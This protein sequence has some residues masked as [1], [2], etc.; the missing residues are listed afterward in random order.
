MKENIKK[1]IYNFFCILPIQKKKIVL[2]NFYNKAYGDNPKYIAEKLKDSKNNY[3]LVWITS[4]KN[5]STLPKKIR[6]AS[7]WIIVLYEYA[8]AKI[9]ISNV[10]L[11]LYLKKRKKQFY[12]QTW[13]GGLGLKKCENDIKETLSEKYIQMMEHDNKMIDLALSNSTF[14]TDLY[15]S[16]MK[17]NGKI[18]E[19]G[20]PRNDNLIKKSEDKDQIKKIFNLKEEKILLYAP[21][22]RDNYRNNVYN[23]DFNKVLKTLEKNGDEWK[24]L[25][26][27]H[28]NITNANELVKF[29][30]KIINCTNYGDINEL[31]KISDALITDYSSCMFDFM[32]LEKPIY[33]YAPDL[34]EFKKERNFYIDI[35]KLPFPL[36]ETT[37]ELYEELNK[38]TIINKSAYKDFN[39][40][41][42][43]NETGK[44]SEE[45]SKIIEKV[46]GGIYE[47]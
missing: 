9:W 13:H 40:K 16:S 37:K 39:K 26:K 38:D 27:F 47:I 12:I 31:F 15:R 5:K 32:L 7:N 42:G 25:V 46:V 43:L 22:F 28:P 11:P 23:V 20:L 6:I 1:I 36:L 29:N 34:K 24:I 19:K 3:D 17:Y 30:N 45:V 21:T 33:L 2:C 35:E 18:L 14:L 10:R 8:T 4:E 44:S 41:F